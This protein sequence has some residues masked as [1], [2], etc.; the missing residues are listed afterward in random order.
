[1][2]SA[3]VVSKLGTMASS[4]FPAGTPSSS[5]SDD[6]RLL[7]LSPDLLAVVGYD[8][9]VRRSNP[10]WAASLPW[11]ASGFDLETFREHVHPD[12]RLA[13]ESAQRTMYAGGS[14]AGVLLRVHDGEGWREIEWHGAGDEAAGLFAIRGADVTEFRRL[15]RDLEQRAERLARTND[16]LQEFAYVAS[17]DLSEPL[18]MVT[19]YLDL[20]V[21]RYDDRLDDTGREFIH[22]A[23][24]GA[25]RMRALIDDLLR[26]ARV[27]ASVVGG[28]DVD[29]DAVVRHVLHDLAAVLEE[30]G[31]EVVIDRPLGHVRGDELQL[32]LLLQNL[33]A[34]A[35]KFR[36]DRP[37]VVEIACEHD[38]LGHRL[39]VR[40]NGIGID[41]QHVDRIFQIFTRLH[42]REAYDGTGIGLSICRRIAERHGGRIE[43][44]S[45]LGEGST[46]IVTLPPVPPGHE[47]D[48]ASGGAA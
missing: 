21:R 43:V 12:D 5:P 25:Q 2:S 26:F 42:P 22:Y 24:D 9:V 11:M 18:R 28:D 16:D 39:T 45:V 36:G 6:E 17:H 33:V 34:N 15:A 4:P 10:A 13:F 30:T 31:A 7:A 48:A 23:V 14:V 32:G 35:V 37:P 27:G 20:I 3:A 8:G 1:M 29:L 41:P 46:F 19:S 47:A 44:A 40:D 38:E